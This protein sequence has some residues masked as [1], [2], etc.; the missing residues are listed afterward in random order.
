M[1]TDNLF[2]RR[3]MKKA[4]AL[5]REEQRREPYDVV[6]IVCEGWEDRTEIF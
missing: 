5:R 3:N 4:A 6:L 1:G 2:H